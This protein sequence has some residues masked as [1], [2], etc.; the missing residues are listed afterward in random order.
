MVDFKFE[1]ASAKVWAVKI[2]QQKKCLLHLKVEQL[3]GIFDSNQFSLLIFQS[4][5]SGSKVIVDFIFELTW[6]GAWAGQYL[7]ITYLDK[8]SL[9]DWS[10]GSFGPRN[11][12]D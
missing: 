9:S 4:I 3:I 11:I 12:E 7:S 6:A 1:I 10:P 8:P 2:I 5:S